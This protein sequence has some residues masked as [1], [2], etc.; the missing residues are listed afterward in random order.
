MYRSILLLG[1]VL[2]VVAC[3]RTM[4]RHPNYTPQRWATDSYEC[5]RDMRQTGSFGT[6]DRPTFY[7]RCLS[8]RGW[9][10]TRE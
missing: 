5:E 8:V 4:Y 10:K 7:E 9:T 3:A 1:V 6:G 2:G